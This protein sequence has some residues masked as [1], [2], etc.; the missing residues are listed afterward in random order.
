MPGIETE[1]EIMVQQI[2]MPQLGESVVEGQIVEWFVKPGDKVSAGDALLEVETDKANTDVPSTGE[3]FVSRLLVAAGETVDV[4]TPLVELV[5]SADE[6]A[7]GGVPAP[8]VAPAPAPAAPAPKSAVAEQPAAPAKPAPVS[9]NGGK[10]HPWK[11]NDMIAAPTSGSGASLPMSAR[12]PAGARSSAGAAALSAVAPLTAPGGTFGAPPGGKYFKPPVIK[13]GP[14]DNVIPFNKRRGII[15]E[16]MVYSKHVS[17]H[18]PC[19][20]EVDVT[21]VMNLRKRNK[22]RY[23]EQGVRLS[24]LAFLLKATCQALREN[25]G[26]N[27]VCGA[28]EIIERADVNLGVAVE[29]PGGLLVPVIRNADSLSVPG[30]AKAVDELAVKA[31]TKKITV[32]DL[33]GGTFTVSN[34]GRRGNLFGAAVINQPQAGIL[35]MGEIVRRPVVRKVEGEEVICI[36]SMMFLSL[37][38][39]HRIIDG[40]KGNGFLYRVRELLEQANFEL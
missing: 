21:E 11:A 35:R 19:F 20:A 27:A 29:T 34:P 38:Y 14:N 17:P 13:A 26:V 28:D 10:H 7:G 6:V 3:G 25:P 2:L 15:S 39:D 32:D 12:A 36:R 30:L 37:S 4:G 8:A 9:D 24:F 33:S 23:E 5:T 18:V 22:S 16:H 1:S 31:R 40:V